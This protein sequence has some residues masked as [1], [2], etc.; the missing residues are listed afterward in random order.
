[1]SITRAI[2]L[3]VL[4]ILVAPFAGRRAWR[5]VRLVRSGQPEP[6]RFKDLFTKRTYYAIQKIIFQRKLL[7]RPGPGIAHALTFWGFL[8]IQIA[9]IE[10]AGEFF[11]KDFRLPIIGTHSWFGFVLDFFCVAVATSLLAFAS[12]A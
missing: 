2:P 12:S 11:W 10:S 6:S 5:L 7:Q 1:L 9:L 3:F 8:I 4:A